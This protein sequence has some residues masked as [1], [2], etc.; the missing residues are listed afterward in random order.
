MTLQSW[1]QLGVD[2]QAP[3]TLV[4]YWMWATWEE[5]DLGEAA[6]HNW[7]NLY[8]VRVLGPDSDEASKAVSLV[9]NLRG[10]QKLSDQNN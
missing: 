5:R 9:E 3:S 1:P 7:G 6:L 2:G 4:S 10:Y 8:R